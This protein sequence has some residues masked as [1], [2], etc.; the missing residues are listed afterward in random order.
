M[1]GCSL[2][3]TF[4]KT[5][6]SV[7]GPLKLAE[8]SQVLEKPGTD[9]PGSVGPGTDGPISVGPGRKR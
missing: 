1:D 5:G 3:D 9:G 7:P 6:P 4:W 2:H 8:C